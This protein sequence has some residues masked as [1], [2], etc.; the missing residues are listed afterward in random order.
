LEQ[1]GG[2]RQGVDDVAGELELLARSG[3]VAHRRGHE[4]R[5]LLHAGRGGDLLRGQRTG[6]PGARGAGG[7]LP[8]D[9][10]GLRAMVLVLDDVEDLGG[11]GRGAAARAGAAGA[12]AALA[13]LRRGLV[14]LLDALTESYVALVAY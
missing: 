6:L 1:E 5:L 8:R 4:L 7:L 14:L 11:V 12:G 2:L 10:E 9:G 3:Q 13:L